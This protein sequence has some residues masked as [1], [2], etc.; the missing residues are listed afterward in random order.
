MHYVYAEHP[1]ALPLTQEPDA[2]IHSM[3]FVGSIAPI[4]CGKFPKI[5][6][7]ERNKFIN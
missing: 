7:K 4:Q 1:V 5:L 6:F 2:K 3:Q